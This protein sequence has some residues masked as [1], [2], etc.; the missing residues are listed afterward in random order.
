L[1]NVDDERFELATKRLSWWVAGVAVLADWVGSDTRHFP[2][3]GDNV[4]DID[5]YWRATLGRAQSALGATGVLPAAVEVGLNFHQLFPAIQTPSPLQ[6]WAAT[7]AIPAQPQIHLLEDVTGA[8]KTEAALTLAA[9]IMAAGQA[10]GFFVGLPTMATANAMYLRIAAAYGRMFEGHANL[11]LAHGR[12]DL[13]EAFAKTVLPA[14]CEAVAPALEGDTASARCTHWLAD[15]NKRALLAQAGVGTIDQALLAGL[16]SKHQSLRLV[17]LF[18]KVLVIDEVHACDAYMQGTLE[19]LLHFHAAAGGSAILLSATL[20]MRMKSSLLRAYA[21]GRSEPVPALRATAYPLVTTWPSDPNTNAVCEQPMDTRA[22]VAR[23]V[24]VLVYTDEARLIEAIVQAAHSGQCV[25][26]IRNTVGDVMAA[27]ALLLQHLPAEKITLFHARFTLGDRLDTEGHVLKHLGPDSGPAERHG[28]VLLATQVAEQSLDVCLDTLATDLA[29][30]DRVVQRAG[31][32]RRHPR[33]MDGRRLPH[34][35]PD[36]RGTPVLWVLA[37]EWDEHPDS[38]W[39]S[40]MFTKGAYV[41]ADHS[42]M[43]LTLQQLRLGNFCMPGDGRKLIEAVFGD[44]VQVPEG[45]QAISDRSTGKAF[46]DRAQAQQRRTK[47]DNGYHRSGTDWLA[48]DSAPSRLGEEAADVLLATWSHGQLLPWCHDKS[49]AWAYSTL[50]VPRR[51]IDQTA[52]TAEPAL[53]EALQTTLANMPGQG[54]WAVLLVLQQHDGA[55]QGD[56]LAAPR[57]QQAAQRFTWTYDKRAGLLK[58]EEAPGASDGAP[59]AESPRA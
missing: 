38:Q 5:A 35:Q 56:A 32:L 13:V 48:D 4:T 54:Q 59:G 28:Q 52:P 50:R 26:W 25:G 2:Y 43:W 39:F 55:W 51:L 33:G 44:D 15:H 23:K 42:Q 21:R 1:A 31:R 10:D 24:D 57:N 47:L 12:K 46:A 34:S 36:Q 22:G 6:H 3:Q 53:A 20:P 40:R 9:R 58:L 45:L 29:P 14:G 18:R 16:E 19:N 17:G 37:P 11:S 8:G 49:D 30:I 7:V 41:Y 27:Y